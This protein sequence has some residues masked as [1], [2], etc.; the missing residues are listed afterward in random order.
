MRKFLAFAMLLTTL[1]VGAMPLPAAYADTGD[2]VETQACSTT[3][4]AFTTGES[5]DGL[6]A[7]GG[8]YWV[9]SEKNAVDAFVSRWEARA[10]EKFPTRDFDTVVVV[11]IPASISGTITLFKNGC[12]TIQG[13]YPTGDA[14]Y[15]VDSGDPA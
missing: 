11:A 8:A 4:E 14:S 2:K 13:H 10:G 1:F 3:L 15:L 5:R 12:A 6:L 9:I 7:A